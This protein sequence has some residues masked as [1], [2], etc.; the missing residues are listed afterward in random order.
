[1]LVII[2][3]LLDYSDK[4]FKNLIV[5][6]SKEKKH[7]QINLFDDFRKTNLSKIAR[8]NKSVFKYKHRHAL[9]AAYL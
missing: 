9:S 1:M 8:I 5:M 2:A 6:L 7:G 3:Y 4:D